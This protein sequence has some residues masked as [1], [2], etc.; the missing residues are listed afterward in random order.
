MRAEKLPDTGALG[1][2]D[3]F[4]RLTYD[5]P[6]NDTEADYSLYK[7]VLEFLG[8]PQALREAHAQPGA[9]DGRL[10]LEED[11]WTSSEGLHWAT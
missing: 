10:I 2:L 4:I 7:Q 9:S 6:V 1:N 5:G 11:D 8:G 3:G